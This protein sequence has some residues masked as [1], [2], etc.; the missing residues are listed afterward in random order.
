MEYFF[1]S[2]L[3]LLISKMNVPDI[4]FV[5]TKFLK[6]K[7]I[8]TMSKVSKSFIN[9][10]GYNSGSKIIPFKCTPLSVFDKSN[11]RKGMI[12]GNGETSFEVLEHMILDF[13]EI[14]KFN[15]V[16]EVFFK[17][18][19]ATSHN[20]NGISSFISTSKSYP[21]FAIRSCENVVLICT[22]LEDTNSYK[23]IKDIFHCELGHVNVCSSISEY[24]NGYRFM[25][26]VLGKTIY[27]FSLC[28]KW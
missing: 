12:V 22:Y 10:W 17:L 6:N 20:V 7:D 24:E 25:I 21:M 28:R 23:L 15:T 2:H 4:W 18:A 27:Q 13:S 3:I 8:I 1:L 14:E 11:I 9:C 19:C 26:R 5:I 16:S